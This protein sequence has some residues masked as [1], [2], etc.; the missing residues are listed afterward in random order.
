VKKQKLAEHALRI[1]SDYFSQSINRWDEKAILERANFLANNFLE[2]WPSLGE[3]QAVPTPTRK[4]KFIKI[5]GDEIPLP[6]QTWREV[7]IQCCEWVIKNRLDR[8]EE[9][10]NLLK[11][12]FR[13]NKPDI[14][15]EGKKRWHQLSNGCW[16]GINKSAKDHRKF[17]R[18]FLAAV[19]ISEAD[20][21][22]EYVSD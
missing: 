4:P 1:N 7:T 10:R 13:D 19:G 5:C 16:V 17:C 2:I 12:N 8:F 21:S 3:H 9:A 15:S 6:K 22:I 14:N 18:R 20:G 11:S